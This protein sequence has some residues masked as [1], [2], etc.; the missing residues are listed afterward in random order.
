MPEKGKGILT[1]PVI[2]N[3]V[4]PVPTR[5]REKTTAAVYKLGSAKWNGPYPQQTG[6]SVRKTSR[7]LQNKPQKPVNQLRN[8]TV[9]KNISSYYK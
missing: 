8:V 5:E 7:I 2:F 1:L 3:T 9:C 6:V 4:L